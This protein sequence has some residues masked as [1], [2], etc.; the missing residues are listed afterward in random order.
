MSQKHFAFHFSF[1]FRDL[2]RVG[3]T[4]IELLIVIGI[5]A[6]LTAAVVIV[7]NP[8]ELLKQSRDSARMTDMA[9]LHKTIQLAMTQNPTISLGTASTVYLS[10]PDTSTT[11]ANLS[12]PT[13]PTGYS[14]HCVPTASSTTVNGQGWLPLDFSTSGIQNLAK[15]PLDP[16]NTSSTGLYYTYIP[17]LTTNTYKFSAATESVKYIPRAQMDGGTSA[18]AFEAGT[19][20][21]L[22][23]GVFPSGW[24]RVPG[25]ST[26]STNDF[27]V[28]QYEA[29]CVQGNTPLTTPN[30]GYN[31]YANNTTPCT[32]TLTPA[33]T[34][35]GYPIAYITQTTAAT[36]CTSIGAHLITNNEWQTIA[37]NI[38]Q[39]A[40]NWSGGVVGSGYLSRGN[41]NA[42]AAQNGTSEYGT[43]YTDFTHK[44]THVLSNGSVLWDIAGNVWDWTNNTI[45]GTNKPVGTAGS[46]VQWTAVS[47]YGSLTRDQV[48][49]ISDAYSSSHNIGQYY[50]GTADA[51]TYGFLRGG[52][53][54]V[55][56]YAGV[57]AL[58]LSD[59]PG[60]TYY[61]V[62]FRCAR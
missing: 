18:T 10:L 40:S 35:G 9:S 49:P 61:H 2:G 38:Q 5:L 37:W 23:L 15:L 59:T 56:T 33:S 54:G 57:G 11:C 13:L 43:G 22:G 3:F 51:T 20:L 29:K 26:F 45:V 34:S 42:S 16:T 24:V 8:A 12:L 28:M 25:N 36:Y 4:L 58:N 14:Y 32:T 62:G 46:W 50:Q 19:D 7:L 55:G 44:R 6:I 48:K 21:T 30:T 52:G 53:W 17:D 27:Y 31:T 1:I 60:Y 39:Q 47:S 41:S